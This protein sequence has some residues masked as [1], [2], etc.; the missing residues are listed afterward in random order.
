MGKKLNKSKIQDLRKRRGNI[1]TILTN[2]LCTE[3]GKNP[4]IKF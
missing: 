3:L 1:Q 2:E 4:K